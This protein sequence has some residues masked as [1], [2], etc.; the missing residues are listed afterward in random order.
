MKINPIHEL[1]E[2]IAIIALWVINV[3]IY[4]AI[5]EN[6][7]SHAPISLIYSNAMIASILTGLVLTH[8]K[9]RKNKIL[10]RWFFIVFCYVI[11]P[12]VW[13]NSKGA[14]GAQSLYMAF[15]IVLTTLILDYKWA[16][17]ISA[18]TVGIVAILMLV[19]YFGLINF[20]YNTP[21]K[22]II[23]SNLIHYII[24]YVMLIAIGIAFKFNYSN[25]QREYY[26]LSVQDELTGLNN[27]RY[28]IKVLSQLISET[29]RHQQ[30]FSVLFIDIDNFKLVNDHD[31]HY[32]GDQVL[33]LL[34]KIITDD[35][36]EYDIGGRYGGDEIIVLLPHTKLIDAKTISSRI[37]SA[38]N[39]QVKTITKQPV[40]LSIGI[41]E[42]E[43]KS[44]EEI[45]RSAD[46]AMYLKKNDKEDTK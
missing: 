40:S 5:L 41:I 9:W 8:S 27:R 31:G 23:L 11:F 10:I 34:G 7:F 17:I 42:N 18:S 1:D 36:R 26:R 46:Q 44:V 29:K 24:V 33:T 32:V 6:L 15:F 14:M 43:N 12:M 22:D 30:P 37:E 16:G 4:F 2:K 45:I 13:L 35:L 28:L 19:E 20:S 21:V 25:F 39:E 38:F 3:S